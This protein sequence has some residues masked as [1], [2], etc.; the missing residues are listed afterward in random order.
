MKQGQHLQ[1]GNSQANLDCL[2]PHH[3]G[4]DFSSESDVG[5]MVQGASP[6]YSGLGRWWYCCVFLDM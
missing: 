3:S 1:L 4:W 2:V 6:V 5:G